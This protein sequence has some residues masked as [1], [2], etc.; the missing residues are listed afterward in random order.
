MPPFDLFF[1]KG[2]SG[3]WTSSEFSI[4]LY[5]PRKSSVTS[6]SSN[7][8]RR[9]SFRKIKSG[10]SM[11]TKFFREN[12]F[13]FKPSQFHV[14]HLYRDLGAKATASGIRAS[15]KIVELSEFASLNLQIQGLREQ[16]HQQMLQSHQVF[17]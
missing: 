16:V 8:N 14:I 10:D 17:Q 1:T 5:S 2:N 12:R 11:D 9:L 3:S 6:G 15:T 13:L 4:W 7:L